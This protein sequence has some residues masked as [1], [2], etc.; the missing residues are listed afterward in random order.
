MDSTKHQ[1]LSGEK[2]TISKRIP[3][4]FLAWNG[5]I[6]GFNLALK[7]GANKTSD[8]T[9]ARVKADLEKRIRTQHF[10][11]KISSGA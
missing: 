7:P 9:R 11:R 1:L 4:K 10:P 8:K 6:T 5:Q 2:A 3:G